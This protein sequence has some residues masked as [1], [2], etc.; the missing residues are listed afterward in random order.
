MSLFTGVLPAAHGVLNWDEGGASRPEGLPTLASILERAGYRTAA[1]T[2]GGNVAA[3]L[4]F[5]HGFD[6]YAD[7]SGTSLALAS[8]ALEDLSR[9]RRPFFLF[10]HTY[11]VHDPYLPPPEHAQLF[12]DPG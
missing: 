7:T 11:A 10:L 12:V 5:D 2:G 4:G 3:G 6:T 1:Y 9:A 8:L